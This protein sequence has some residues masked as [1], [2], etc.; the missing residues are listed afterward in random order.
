[1]DKPENA[2]EPTKTMTAS[3]TLLSRKRVFRLVKTN[4]LI[5]KLELKIT[6]E[7]KVAEIGTSLNLA[8]GPSFKTGR[9]V[10]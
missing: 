8:G 1:M 9:I 7:G 2:L 6:G 3:E 5:W 4:L 10:D